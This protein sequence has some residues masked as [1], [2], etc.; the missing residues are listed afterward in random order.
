MPGIVETLQRLEADDRLNVRET[1]R[2]LL[3]QRVQRTDLLPEEHVGV[4]VDERRHP[5]HRKQGD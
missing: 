2:V 5:Q 1:F 4:R 3:R